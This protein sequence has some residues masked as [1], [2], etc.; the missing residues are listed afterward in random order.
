MCE[1]AVVLCAPSA[2]APAPTDTQSCLR[3]GEGLYG[4]AETLSQQSRTPVPREFARVSANLDEFCESRE[5]DKA[6]I[7]I[8]WMERCLKNYRKPYKLGF[9]QRKKAYFCAVDPQSDG[10]K[11]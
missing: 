9:C 11:G 2:G 3:A 6:R 1:Q 7:S 8:E 10:C 4:R 5:F